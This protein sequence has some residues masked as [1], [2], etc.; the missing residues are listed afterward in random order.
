MNELFTPPNISSKPKGKSDHRSESPVDVAATAATPLAEEKTLTSESQIGLEL[1][2]D[3]PGNLPALIKPASDAK[4][5]DFD[6]GAE[7]DDVVLRHQL[8][9]AIYRNT[10]DGLVIRQ[11]RD[12]NDDDDTYIVI[13][14]ENIDAFIDKL[15]DVAGIQSF[16]R[17]QPAARKVC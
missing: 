6:W 11:G 9:I 8:A 10:L 14:P 17:P 2:T 7:N 4:D 1:S 3:R 5:S 15:A 12:W 13:S 16:G